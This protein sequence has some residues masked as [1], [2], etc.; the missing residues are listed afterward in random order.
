METSLNDDMRRVWEA[1]CSAQDPCHALSA[2]P[3]SIVGDLED[4]PT[5]AP[6]TCSTCCMPAGG[7]SRKPCA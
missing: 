4:L 2:D 5:W 3:L 1:L 7:T 6:S